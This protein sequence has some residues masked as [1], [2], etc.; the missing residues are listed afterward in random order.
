MNENENEIKEAIQNIKELKDLV[1][2]KQKQLQPMV[3]SKD[4]INMLLYASLFLLMTTLLIAFG[5]S[6]YETFWDFPLLLKGIIM[7]SIIINFIQISIKKIK[8][9]NKNT[10]ISLTSSINEIFTIDFILAIIL[11][12]FFS[13]IFAS[14]TK[15]TW[16]YL[17]IITIVYGLIVITFSSS[18]NLI[19]FKYMGYLTI[20][21][22]IIS[23]LFIQLPLLLLGFSM[24]TIIFFCYYLLL[25][26]ARRNK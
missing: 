26:F 6:K 18:I 5:F 24:Y 1:S 23:M 2:N 11:A 19:E 20:F 3:L 17:P 4:F 25:K 15:L 21:I 8:A 10:K 13:T 12:I 7:L 14:I 9:L 16:V 22:G